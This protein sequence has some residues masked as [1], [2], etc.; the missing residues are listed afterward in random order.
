MIKAARLDLEA[1][2]WTPFVYTI[3]FVGFD[4]S[5]AILLAAQVRD[6]KDGGTIRANLVAVGTASQ[7]GVRLVNVIYNNGIPTSTI[8][9]RI[10]ETTM[11]AMNV[12]LEPGEDGNLWWDF[13]IDPGGSG[14]KYV[15]L[16]GKFKVKA[17]VTQ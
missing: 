9:F 15:A 5:T 4:F 11:E 7:E 6:R 3:D 2:R 10:N 8:S 13:H 16:E 1:N 12:A 14:L 17:G